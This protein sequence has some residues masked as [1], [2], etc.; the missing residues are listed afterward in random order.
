MTVTFTADHE[1]LL[2][3]DAKETVLGGAYY[4]WVSPDRAHMEKVVVARKHRGL[5]VSHGLMGEFFRRLR[6]QGA[7]S[8]ET[9]YFQPE[10][11]SRYGFRTD[12]SSGGLMADLVEEEAGGRRGGPRK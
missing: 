9:G 8:V 6:A 10:Y 2:A 4:R 12:P 1:F 11:L 5:G 7:K 3:F